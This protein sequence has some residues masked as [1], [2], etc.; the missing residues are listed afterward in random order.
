MFNILKKN[1]VNEILGLNYHFKINNYLQENYSKIEHL[2]MGDICNIIKYYLSIRDDLSKAG[3]KIHPNCL[4]LI[5]ELKI[6]KIKS[7]KQDKTKRKPYIELSK[8]NIELAS[9]SFAPCF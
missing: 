1:F 7:G 8:K 3:N 4:F 9:V 2:E 5:E 6:G